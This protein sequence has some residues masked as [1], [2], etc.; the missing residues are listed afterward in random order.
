M[1]ISGFNIIMELIFTHRTDDRII[2]EKHPHCLP[3][4]YVGSIVV[5]VDPS[6]LNRVVTAQPSKLFIVGALWSI[7]VVRPSWCS[8]RLGPNAGQGS[9]FVIEDGSVGSLVLD[10]CHN[11]GVSDLEEG[12][13]PCSRVRGSSMEAVRAGTDGSISRFIEVVEIHLSHCEIFSP[14]SND[15]IPGSTRDHLKVIGRV[16][17]HNS[18]AYSGRIVSNLSCER[19]L[20]ASYQIISHLEVSEPHISHSF[21]YRSIDLVLVP[22]ELLILGG[23]QRILMI[24]IVFRDIY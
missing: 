10:L 7:L 11:I 16:P 21:S 12:D 19:K 20:D 14:G 5:K 3:I 1:S 4:E 17:H 22:K 6:H 24:H 2:I 9:V 13:C 15:S 8:P 23:D 18:L